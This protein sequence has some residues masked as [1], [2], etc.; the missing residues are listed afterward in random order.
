MSAQP[1]PHE[2]TP[3]VAKIGSAG[4]E[5]KSGTYSGPPESPWQVSR[6]NAVPGGSPAQTMV[7][8]SKSEP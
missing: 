6:G 2:T 5:P 8:G 4:V 1:K 7:S 3:A